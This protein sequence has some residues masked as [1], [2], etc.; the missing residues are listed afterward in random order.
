M[1]AVNDAWAF[2]QLW[3]CVSLALFAVVLTIGAVFEDGLQK[4]M[5][6]ARSEGRPEPKLLD[7]FIRI[8]FL[9]LAIFA[10]IVGPMVYKPI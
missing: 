6:Q 9:D 8:G 10:G 4:R 1:V 7:R 2:S 3:V 5:E